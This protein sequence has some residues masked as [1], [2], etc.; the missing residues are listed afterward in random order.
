[1]GDCVPPVAQAAQPL[2]VGAHQVG[3]RLAAGHCARQAGVDAHRRRGGGRIDSHPA[4]AA[5]EDLGPGVR[6]GLAHRDDPVHRIDVAALVARDDA[7]RNA[8]RAHQEHEC[9][10]EVLAEAGARV[11]QEVV[12]RMLAEQRRLERVGEPAAAQVRDPLGQ[13]VGVRRGRTAPLL[14]ERQSARIEVRRQAKGAAQQG[15]LLVGPRF[16]GGDRAQV[17][18]QAAAHQ[19]WRQ[20]HSVGG[21]ARPVGQGGGGLKGEQ[22]L[23]VVRLEHHAVAVGR[24]A[25]ARRRVLREEGRPH[26]PGAAVEVPQH[27]AAPVEQALRRRLALELRA[28]GDRIRQGEARQVARRHGVRQARDPGVGVLRQAPEGALHARKQQ[29][30]HQRRG[31]GVREQQPRGA[32]VGARRAHRRAET[33]QRGGEHEKAEAHDERRRDRLRV[34]EIGD[35]QE[36]A[37]KRRHRRV[38]LGARF[39]ELQAGEHHQQQ[40][41]GAAAEQRAAL[42]PDGEHRHRG[43]AEQQPARRQRRAV[44]GAVRAPAEEAESEKRKPPGRAQGMRREHQGKRAD[45]PAEVARADRALLGGEGMWKALHGAE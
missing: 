22:P 16:A 10:G 30:Q 23:S 41:P 31:R 17:V 5:Q 2:E 9:R 19:E 15:G 11:E 8:R 25:G 13:H 40:D 14:R 28:K 20:H 34:E 4:A 32:Q 38:A 29:K 35:D 45:Q 37:E 24:P 12:H 7:R 26:A 21:E 6:V 3:Q 18:A 42:E 1:M 36:E 27:R 44:Q 43:H 33:D 39:H